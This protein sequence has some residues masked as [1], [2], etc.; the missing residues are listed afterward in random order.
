MTKRD[1][2]K[3]AM[4]HKEV[5]YVP[6]QINLTCEARD[7]LTSYYGIKDIDEKIDNHFL[8]LGDVYGFFDDI[9]NNRVKDLFGVIWNRE[10]DKDIGIVEGQVL[11]EPTVENLQMPD[12]HD[13]RLFNGIEERIDRHGDRFRVFN[14]GFSLF[15]R[16]WTLRGMEDLLMDFYLNPDFVRELL[17]IIADWNIAV[18][19]KAVSYDI[20]C[21]HFGDDWGQQ[22]G[23]IMGYPIWREFLYPELK[24]MY[25][26]GVE[27]GKMVSIH[28]CGDVD[29]LFDDLIEIGLNNFNPFQ[30]EVMDVQA[31]FEQ[32]R[33]KLCFY[34]GL[35][36][37]KIL[38][39]GSVSDVVA[40]SRKLLEMGRKGGFIFSP[41][42]AVESDV[43][44]ENLV[45]MIDLLQ[46]QES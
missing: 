17:H 39:Y 37:Q 29:E 7:S 18:M 44:V 28:S 41:A 45:A 4:G 35:S 2:V 31:L 9:G 25:S 40:E 42:H 14:L 22:H 30:P 11:P 32:Y 15:E 36:T 3:L 20:D 16:A 21:I 6:W 5:P 19:K 1:V 46:N 23:L 38:P 12:P 27:A 10:E 24:R 33:G 43:P 34:G 26:V 13:P 8:M